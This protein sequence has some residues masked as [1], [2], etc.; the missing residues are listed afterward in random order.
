MANST[1]AVGTT[2]YQINALG[3]RIRKTNSGGG[4][5]FHYDDRGHLI[6]ETTAAGA[7]VREYAWIGNAPVA[8]M[9]GSAYHYV[10]VDHLNTP[11]LVTNAVA[12]EVWSWHQAEPFGN[13]VPDEN[14]N[15]LG[16]FDL[17]LRFPGHRY[18]PETGLHYNYFRDYD[19]ALGRYGESDPIGLAGGPNIYV[20]GMADP[21][22]LVDLDGREPSN[23]ITEAWAMCVR[24]CI[25]GAKAQDDAAHGALAAFGASPQSGTKRELRCWIE[26]S[27]ATTLSRIVQCWVVRPPAPEHFGTPSFV[28]GGYGQAGRSPRFGEKTNKPQPPSPAPKSDPPLSPEN[29]DDL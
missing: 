13:N 17:P 2:N 23:V 18:D 4:Q 16:A 11:R 27:G 20:Y 6:A 25:T 28:H 22:R 3:Q 15:G 29:P 8:V 14:P 19:P 1:S 9:N 21:L 10:H 7:L 26:C 5:V 24:R 12:Q